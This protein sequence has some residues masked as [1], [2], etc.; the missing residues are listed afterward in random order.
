MRNY[1]V[2]YNKKG[3]YVFSES[4]YPF[5]VEL[6]AADIHDDSGISG[7]LVSGRCVCNWV[8]TRETRSGTVLASWAAWRR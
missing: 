5:C 3:L 2:K 1:P 6:W 8:I 4:I 7:L